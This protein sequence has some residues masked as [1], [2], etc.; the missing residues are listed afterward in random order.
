MKQKIQ[1]LVAAAAVTLAAAPAAHAGGYPVF[2]VMNFAEAV[3]QVTNQIETIQKL[4]AQIENQKQMLQGWGYTQVDDLRRRMEAVRG[5][6][7]RAG[8][9]YTS[10]NPGTRLDQQFPTTFD[11]A[12]LAA[13]RVGSLRDA[14]V[15]SQRSVLV[16][17][18]RVQNAVYGDL[19][20]T[21]TRV[22]GYVQRSNAAPGMTAAVQANNELTATLIGQ[23]QALQTL[24]ITRARAEVEAEARRQSEEEFAREAHAWLS[25]ADTAKVPPEGASGGWAVTPVPER[26]G[27]R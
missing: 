26:A 14:W 23:V 17:N 21:Q 15:A 7:R 25:R 11:V 4:S 20:A 5:E 19:A 10:A 6:L 12:D 3:K 9:V 24:E 22:T 16:E 18:R 27:G 2:D 1:A 8:T 13:D